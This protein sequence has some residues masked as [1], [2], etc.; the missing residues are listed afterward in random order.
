MAVR[1]TPEE[2]ADIIET[3]LDG[4]GGRWDWD[5]F[6]SIRIKDPDLDAVRRRCVDLHEEDPYPAAQYCGPAGLEIMRGFV[7]ALRKK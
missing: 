4:T 6:C 2:V 5:D 3:F 1:L 7:T